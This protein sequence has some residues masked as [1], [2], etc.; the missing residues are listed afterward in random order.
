[1]TFIIFSLLALPILFDLIFAIFILSIFRKNFTSII[2]LNF[3]IA[4]LVF[5]IDVSL[6]KNEKHGYFYRAHEKYTTKKKNY[7]KNISDIIFMPHGD[8]YAIDSGLNKKREQIKVPREQQFITDSYGIRNDKTNIEDAEIILVG[9]SFITGIGTTQKHIPSNLL[10]KIS[11]KKVASLSYGGLDPKDYEMFINKYLSIIRKDAKIFVF[12]FEGNDFVKIDNTSNAEIDDSKYFEWRGHQIPLIS[13]KIRFAYERL[14]RNKDKFLLR[15]LSEKNYFL[16]N[17]R[18]KSHL[19][20][21]KFFSRLHS[22]G[23]PV[24]YF[25][26][27]NKIVGFL[28]TDNFEMSNEYTTYIFE[29]K[30]ILERITAFFFIPTKLRIYSPYIST[31]TYNSNNKLE[32]LI[33]S[34]SSLDKPV[35]DLSKNMNLSVSKYLSDGKYLYWRDDTHWNHNGIYEAMSYVSDIIKK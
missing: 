20:Y 3:F 22:T 30:K 16:R 29:N 13:G 31:I 32:Y 8:I 27:G 25:E 24:K 6:G 28:H 2:I 17:I 10:S 12:Y 9:D 18:A 26:I 7:Q 1:M 35:Y 34:Y 19:M 14:E 4:T 11:G 5:V 33:N 15:I 21:R 23:S